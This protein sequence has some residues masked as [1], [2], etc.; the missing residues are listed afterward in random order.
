MTISLPKKNRTDLS[1]NP[2]VVAAS[3]LSITKNIVAEEK[4]NEFSSIKSSMRLSRE[5]ATTE[6]QIKESDHP[7]KKS[8]KIKWIQESCRHNIF[9]QGIAC[10]C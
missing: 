6:K 10:V 9:F 7:E 5:L 3:R 8:M 2:S 1:L 4:K